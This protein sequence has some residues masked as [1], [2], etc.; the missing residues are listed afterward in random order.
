MDFTGENLLVYVELRCKVYC[1]IN[2][3]VS[4][5]VNKVIT[6]EARVSW[7]RGGVSVILVPE[8]TGNTDVSGL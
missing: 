5:G 2:E 7:Y 6:A 3:C 8:L 4:C 1:N